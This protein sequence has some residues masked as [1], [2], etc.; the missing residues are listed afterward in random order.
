MHVPIETARGAREEARRLGADCA[1]AIGGG[2]TTGL[3]KA[4]ALE[5]AGGTAR[6]PI[7]AIPTTYAGSEMTPIWGLTEGGVKKTGRDPRVLPAAVIYDPELTLTLP[8]G[9]TVTSAL[10]AIAH[11]A[12]GLYAHDGNPVM[13]LMAEEGIRAAATALPPLLKDARDLE[14]RS[15]ALYAAWLCG[16]V[17]IGQQAYF[18][19]G[20]Y[21]MLVL[22]N[23][24]GVNPFLAV[25]LGALVA[26]AISV[27]VSFVAFRLAGGYFAIGT[28]VIAEVFRLG[29]ANVSAVGGG[30]GTSL[31]ALR[32]IEKATRETATYGLALACTVAA[33]AA[34]YLFLR[35]KRGLALL[36]IR[37]NEVAA[38]SQGIDVRGM[39]PS[40]RLPLQ[41]QTSPEDRSCP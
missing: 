25:P 3:G 33:I 31:T 21:A 14:A 32:G 34:V 4:I 27:P 29:V 35:S 9:L 18:G 2:S 7:L 41:K 17:S 15:D 20:G 36:A 23:V 39:P 11:A 19:L 24:T 12:E 22:A 8:L 10:N 6:F 13:S 1:V 16:M 5:A 26:A 37:D 30:S 38:E 28:W 40:A